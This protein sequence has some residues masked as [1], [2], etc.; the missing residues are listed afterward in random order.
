[1]S[2][3]VS[4]GMH[5][6]T[7]AGSCGVISARRAFTASITSTVFLPVCFCSISRIEGRP[8]LWTRSSI[9]L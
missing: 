3:E 2:L 6:V 5:T 1:M 8:L 7:S 9:G 4:M